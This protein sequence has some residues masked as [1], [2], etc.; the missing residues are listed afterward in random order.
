MTTLFF[1][2]SHKDSDLR[3]ELE[4]HL[5]ILKRNGIIDSWHDRCIEA[6]QVIDHEISTHLRNA[7]IILL[8]VSADFLASDYCYDVEMKEAMKLHEKKEVAVIPVILRP[9]YWHDTPFGKLLA[10][11]TDGKP[12]TGFASI[13]EA[14]L[15]VTLAI[16]KVAQSVSSKAAPAEAAVATATTS[17]ASPFVTLMLRDHLRITKRTSSLTKRLIIWP[18]ILLRDLPRCNSSERSI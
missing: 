3:T 9:C 6:G 17:F 13:D 5:S 15:D 10:T 16:R 4:K 14:F 12:V 2:Y 18:D 1:S 8:L 11:P 7:N